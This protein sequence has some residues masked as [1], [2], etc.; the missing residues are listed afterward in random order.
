[1]ML[2]SQHETGRDAQA[3]HVDALLTLVSE[4]SR[5]SKLIKKVI[6]AV[7]VGV[8]LAAAGFTI[9]GNTPAQPMAQALAALQSDPAVEVTTSS[10]TVFK[11]SGSQADTGMIFYPGGRVDY[12]AYAPYL[13]ALAAQGY[14][15]VLVP[16][17]LNLAVFGSEKASEVIQAY[18]NVKH[19]L[20]GGHSLGGAMAAH[21]VALHPEKIAGLVLLASYPAEADNLKSIPVKV[22]SIHGTQDGLATP[23]KIDASRA[24]LPQDTQIVSI[25]G[26]NHAQ[27]GWYGLQ[28]GDGTASISREEQQAQLL[29]TT[30]AFL[31]AISGK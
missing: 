1:M 12:R 5:S 9:W 24:L 16:M 30:I 4:T 31:Q 21:Y 26:G 7:L 6:I 8:I 29:Q 18:P 14:L 22:I 2:K 11:P 19:W 23:A 27:F 15:V 20:I 28:S 13:H 3:M 25:Q 17:P 10:W